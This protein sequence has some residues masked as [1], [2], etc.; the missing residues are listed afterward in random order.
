MMNVHHLELFYYVARHGGISAAVRHMPYGIQQPAISTQIRLLERDLGQELFERS[1]FRLTKAGEE[2][3]AF[4]RPFFSNLDALAARLGQPAAP[5][6]RIGAAELMLRD[7]LPPIVERLKAQHPG[8][9]LS[10]RS[11]F[12]AQLEESVRAHEIDV[13][14]VPRDGRPPTGLRCAKLLSLPLVLLVPAGAKL[15]SAAELW[16]RDRIEPP[17]I[18][19]PENEVVGRIFRKELK[20]LWVDWPCAIEASSL[21][22]ISQYV[23]NGY[24]YGVS[25]DL[26]GIA[27]GPKIRSLPL[28]GFPPVEVVMLWQGRETPLIQ[29]ILAEA[30]TYVA[31]QWPKSRTTGEV[32]AGRP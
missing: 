32:T 26:D 5:T 31:R 29:A 13:A 12:T 7:C 17:L 6:L 1:P 30:K 9:Q 18:C 15:Q 19:L 10:L 3:F 27:A 25:V 28:K 14:I 4:V 20:R 8:L 21:D 24:G 23:A 16:A 11:G 22:L 2:L